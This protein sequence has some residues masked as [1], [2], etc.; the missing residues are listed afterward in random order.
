MDIRVFQRVTH[1]TPHTTPH[2]HHTTTQDTT[3]HNNTTTTPHD[4][5]DRERQ[6]QTETKSEEKREER[7]EKREERREERREKRE[8]RREK[9]EEIHFQCGGAWPFFV[10][11]V[12]C[13]VKPVDARAKQ[14]QVRFIL[15]FSA[16]WQVNSFL[17]SA[18]Y[19]F[20]AV[21]VFKKKKYF[22]VTQLQFSK[23]SE[24]FN[25]AATVFCFSGINSA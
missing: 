7:R 6:R 20:Y 2:T 18:N 14:C 25:Y 21:A 23:F 1:H 3:Y 24:L 22:L 11:G 17:I 4:N 9:R 10:H 19:L 12:L 8:E 16:P 13:L 5:R 15:D